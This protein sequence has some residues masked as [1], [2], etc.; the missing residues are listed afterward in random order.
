[1]R[2][3]SVFLA[4]GLGTRLR[5]LTL[6]T[7]KCLVQI[8][9]RPLLDYWFDA[10]A[11]AGIRDVLINTHYLADQVRSY[12]ER[13]R[14]AGFLVTEAHEPIL[15]GSAGTI[16]ANAAWADDADLVLVIYP[17]NLSDVDLGGVLQQ[18]AA[19][20]ADFSMLLF[21]APNPSACGIATQNKEGTIT[22]FVEKPDLPESDLANGGI[23][24]MSAGQWREIARMNAFDIGFDVLPLLVGRMHGITHGGLHMDIGNLEALDRAQQVSLVPTPKGLPLDSNQ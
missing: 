6:R 2:V 20:G 1:M 24:V 16:T 5:P 17:D 13:K 22:S 8:Q 10:I 7:P 11:A 21:H 9:G 19:F 3:K 14:E 18:H 12:L 23:Y 15:L 4:A